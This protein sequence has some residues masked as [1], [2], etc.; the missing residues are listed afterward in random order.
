MQTI[1]EQLRFSYGP[2][3]GIGHRQQDHLF[4][5]GPD[6]GFSPC[7]RVYDL[8]GQKEEKEKNARACGRFA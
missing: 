5:G 2:Y 3:Q 8:V 1:Q 4:P 7:N 6:G